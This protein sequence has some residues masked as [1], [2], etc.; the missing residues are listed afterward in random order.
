MFLVSLRGRK[1]R[2]QDRRYCGRGYLLFI[3]NTSSVRAKWFSKGG[4]SAYA[5][6]AKEKQ[7]GK[8]GEKK[9]TRRERESG[10]DGLARDE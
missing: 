5:T 2:R 3:D 10:G 1:K 7:R 8:E 4:V 9:R 6:G